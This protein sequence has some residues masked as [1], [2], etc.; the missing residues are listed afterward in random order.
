M[1]LQPTLGAMYGMQE[2]VCLFW[3][4]DTTDHIPQFFH[5]N[6]SFDALTSKITQLCRM[7]PK[8]KAPPADACRGGELRLK[9]DYFTYS[10]LG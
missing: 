9:E 5:P 6:C 3:S 10:G 7:P 4:Q 1:A 8:K 2:K